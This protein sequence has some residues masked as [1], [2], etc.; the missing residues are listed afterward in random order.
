MVCSH[1]RIPIASPRQS[2]VR[3]R[4]GSGAY[5]HNTAH[6]IASAPGI[7]GKISQLCGMNGTVRHTA[8]HAIQAVARP[9]SNSARS[10]TASAASAAKKHSRITAPR[11]PAAAYA[12]ASSAGR[13]GA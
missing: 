12:G 10:K 7:S 13:P 5:N 8:D 4:A 11:Y 9:A 6:A 1:G 3:A 2:H